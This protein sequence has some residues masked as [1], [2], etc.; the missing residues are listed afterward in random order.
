MSRIE[1]VLAPPNAEGTRAT[2]LRWCKAVG[3]TV[4]KD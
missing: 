1:D 3:D 4:I 2:I